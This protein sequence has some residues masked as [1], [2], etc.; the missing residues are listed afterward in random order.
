MT[1]GN[2]DGTADGC[3][4]ETPFVD[5]APSFT[6]RCWGDAARVFGSGIGDCWDSGVE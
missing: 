3:E 4:V 5:T 6:G 1:F 2:V